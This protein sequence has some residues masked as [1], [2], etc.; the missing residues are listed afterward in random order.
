MHNHPLGQQRQQLPPPSSSSPGAVKTVASPPPLPTQSTSIQPENRGPSVS[1]TLNR[2][3]EV[4][5]LEPRGSEQFDLLAFFANTRSQIR[6]YFLL[7]V[8]SHQSVKW[9]LCT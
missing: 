8:S 3:V 6:D 1:N 5:R 4:T 7:R 2:A 9:Y